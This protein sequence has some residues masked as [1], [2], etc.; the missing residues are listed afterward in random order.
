MYHYN[1][2]VLVSEKQKEL[3]KAS[4]EAWKFADFKP[5]SLFQ[6]IVKRFTFI[7]SSKVEN[8][9]SNCECVCEC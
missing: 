1:Y 3:E 8:K 7:K 2:E 4:F 6:K 5:E 9:Q